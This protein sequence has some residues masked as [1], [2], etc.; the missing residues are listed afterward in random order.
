M[1]AWGQIRLKRRLVQLML[2]VAMSACVEG[3]AAQTAA[4]NAAGAK[5]VE[6]D[7]VVAIVNND[8]ILESDV[9]AEQ[10]FQA[11]QLG[12]TKPKTRDELIN[13]LINRE[14]ILQQIAI[15][16]EPPIPE[17]N[18]DTALMELRKTIPKC[19]AYHCETD[20]GWEKFVRDQGLTLPELR[21]HWKL[22]I[23]VLQFIEERF[24]MG[25][26]ITDQEIDDYYQ[27]TLLPDYQKQNAQAPP[28]SA[29]KDKIQEI[30]LQQQV[31]KLLEDWLKTLRAQGS[32]RV[33]KPGEE[34]P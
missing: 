25:I 26:R 14:L 34:A 7:R 3:A 29:I 4:G 28:E 5:P 16:P 12:S 17:S 27:K 13:R 18:V 6:L 30:L 23:E 2:A 20:A 33:L 1:K 24:R 9:D 22:R 10:R 31:D 8:L 15:Q 19:E 32:V 11:F 21:A